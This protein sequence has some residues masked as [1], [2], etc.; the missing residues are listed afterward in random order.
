[1]KQFIKLR[2]VSPSTLFLPSCEGNL[3]KTYKA[4]CALDW[5]FAYGEMQY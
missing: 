2:F 4:L 3:L 5:T 1:M